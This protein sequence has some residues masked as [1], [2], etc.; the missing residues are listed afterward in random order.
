M[1]HTRVSE[2]K[3]LLAAL[4]RSCNEEAQRGGN[5]RKMICVRDVRKLDMYSSLSGKW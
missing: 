5:E 2:S 4:A 1:R 3:R